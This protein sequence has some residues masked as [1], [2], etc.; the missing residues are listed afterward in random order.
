MS[1]Q[2]VSCSSQ[3]EREREREREIGEMGEEHDSQFKG[4]S[5]HSAISV[6][7]YNLL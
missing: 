4:A 3:P 7:K 1:L 6:Q 2:R 5:V